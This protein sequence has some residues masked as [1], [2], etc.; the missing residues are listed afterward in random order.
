VRLLGEQKASA[1][2]REKS[3]EPVYA[4][5]NGAPYCEVFVYEVTMLSRLP[6]LLL[7]FSLS[8]VM[9]VTAIHGTLIIYLAAS[10]PH[11]DFRTMTEFVPALSAM[12]R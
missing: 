4:P 1:L 6:N 2:N 9:W 5:G 7:A 8:L 10:S 3:N 11:V 12:I